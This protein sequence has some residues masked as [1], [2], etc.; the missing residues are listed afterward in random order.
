VPRGISPLRAGLLQ[1]TSIERDA[2]M[3]ATVP[4]V[5]DRLRALDFKDKSSLTLELSVLVNIR[6]THFQWDGVGQ[7]YCALFRI[8]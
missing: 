1:E 3:T 7:P 6:A 4:T 8:S 5:A 2:A